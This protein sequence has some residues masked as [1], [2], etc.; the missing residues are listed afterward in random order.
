MRFSP[1]QRAASIP[2]IPFVELDLVLGQKLPVLLLKR[3][4]AV[5]LLLVTDVVRH[6]LHIGF[7]HRERPIP[8]LPRKARQRRLLR[9]DPFG[10]RLLH[11]LHHLR[12]RDRAAHVEK[13]M[14]MVRHRVD[15][16]HWGIQIRQHRGEVRMKIRTH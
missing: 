4:H 13:Q 9:L 1:P 16:H 8:R 2:H 3:F 7:A 12:Q 6:L 15:E 10:R 14:H 11:V 5:V